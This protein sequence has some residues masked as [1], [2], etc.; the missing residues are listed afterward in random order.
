[1]RRHAHLPYS[2]DNSFQSMNWKNVDGIF[3]KYH[4][5]VSL[6]RGL[7]TH[8]M[9]LCSSLYCSG[10]PH[11]CDSPCPGPPKPDGCNSASWW[12]FK[13]FSTKAAIF[14]ACLEH[15]LDSWWEC[16]G[17]FLLKKRLDEMM[18]ASSFE[19]KLD[20][21]WRQSKLVNLRLM[22]TVDE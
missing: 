3:N 1:M 9:L 10:W 21:F 2:G 11:R 19:D 13:T 4:M 22:N 20:S 16:L 7:V 14:T 8:A 5:I 6:R 15:L 17:S 18:G 12:L